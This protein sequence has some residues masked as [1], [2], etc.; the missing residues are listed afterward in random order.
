MR[1]IRMSISTTSGRLREAYHAASAVEAEG[2]LTALAQEL[3]KTH[4]GAAASLREG[5]AETLTILRLGV[6]PGMPGPAVM[7]RA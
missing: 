2:L 3:D 4:P 5:M 1:G 7:M 6:P